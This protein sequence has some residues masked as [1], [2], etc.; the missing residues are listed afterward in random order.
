V[1]IN[2]FVAVLDHAVAAMGDA[3]D[4]DWGAA[5]G[6][7]DWTCWETVDHVIDCVFSYAVQVAAGAHG[8]WLPLELHP[9]ST[10]RPSE[11]VEGLG[12]V[13]AV[14]ATVLRAAPA[15]AVASDGFVSLNVADWAARGA[16]EVAVHAHD[17]LSGLAIA[18]EV[19]AT[20]CT[21]IIA[22]PGMWFI[23]RARA[24]D[25]ADPWS[26][27]LLGSGRDT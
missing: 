22:S 7:L 2:D 20:I 11:L 8:G 19:P 23:D 9:L 4:H 3:T 26:A 15:D 25:A 12:T 13:G 16:Y 18:F 10:A 14:F 21:G 5:A 24:A 27:L 17:V 6:T 1:T